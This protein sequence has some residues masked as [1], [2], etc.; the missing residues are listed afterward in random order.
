MTRFLWFVLL[1]VFP[2]FWPHFARA[3]AQ[4]PTDPAVFLS[5]GTLVD[6]IRGEVYPDVG[7]VAEGGKITGLFFDFPYNT[8]RIPANAVRVDVRGKYLLPGMM[9]LHAH[10]NSTYKG[11]KIDLPHMMKIFLVGGVTTIRAMGDGDDNLVHLKN[12]IDMGRTAGPNIVIG[13]F[14]PFEQAPGFPRLERTDIVNT[15]LEARA[16]TRDHIFKGA[17]WVKFYNYGD[18][19]I[20]RAVVDEAHKHGAK[21]F[22]HFTMLGADD[23]ARAGVDSLEHTTSLI[24]KSLDYN[25][26][27]GMTDIG[28]YRYFVL[29]TKLDQK[30]L[31]E[32]FKVMIEHKTAL[33]PTLAIQYVGAD[34]NY[35]P[36]VSGEWFDLY[37]KELYAAY[38]K[39][40]L[41]V[42]A[43]YNFRPHE[44]QWKQSILAQARHVA[45]FVKM[46][47]K[48]GTGSDLS[49][50]PPLVPGLSIRQELEL[51][52][53]GGMTPLEAVR[54]ATIGAAEILGWQ[55]RFGSIEVGKQADVVVLNANPL[56]DIRAVGN[57]DSVMQAGKV[58]RI[59]ELT[60][61]LRKAP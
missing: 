61:E 49:P 42:P 9:D 14:P 2:A 10:A 54:T 26:Q 24:Q 52:V 16:F 40:P 46:G 45:R 35:L 17:T 29:W 53:Q 25:E 55:E 22:G 58:Y 50:A 48:V 33:V 56:A 15:P 43:V 27:I 47:G 13:S 1:A 34:P 39:D 18:S 4:K 32:T 30:K 51:F 21:V 5:G 20:V 57:I 60:T 7:V 19:D 6:V 38:L 3:Q 44:E 36:K 37:Q 59:N 28:Y 11:V 8:E 31:D 41:R 12:D 23:A